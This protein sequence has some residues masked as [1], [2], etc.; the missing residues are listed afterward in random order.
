MVVWLRPVLGMGESIHLAP[1][2]GGGGMLMDRAPR[3]EIGGEGRKGWFGGNHLLQMKGQ[4]A[5]YLDRDF[6]NFGKWHTIRIRIR[7]REQSI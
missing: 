3:V 4:A 1:G 2:P 6:D 5:S 7:V